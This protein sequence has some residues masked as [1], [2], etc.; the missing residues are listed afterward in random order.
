MKAYSVVRGVAAAAMS[1]S[2]VLLIAGVS[3][4]ADA[5]FG[6]INYGE[7]TKRS[8]QIAAGFNDIRQMQQAAQAKINSLATDMNA[9]EARLNKEKASLSP[10]DKEKLIN[11]VKEKRQEIESQRQALRVKIMFKQ[12]SLAHT[13]NPL[14]P[15][16][17]AK[18]AKDEGLSA[19]FKADAIVYSTDL[20][21]ISDK[22]AKAVD[23]AFVPSK[24]QTE[25]KTEQTKPEKKPEKKPV[26]KPKH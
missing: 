8:A 19:V 24:S 26:Q 5:K 6:V 21:D 12:K 4:A 14:L 15:K 16:I 18:I 23:E 10:K 3:T 20:V 1:L 17:I 7:V 2:L 11:E 9:L 13:L 22:V 25:P